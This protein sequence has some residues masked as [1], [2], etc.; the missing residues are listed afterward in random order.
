MLAWTAPRATSI[1][2]AA[3]AGAGP[4][5]GMQQDTRRYLMDNPF[6]LDTHCF[7]LTE[8]ARACC[9]SVPY[10]APKAC[11]RGVRSS[12]RPP[13]PDNHN[14]GHADHTPRYTVDRS[15]S[16]PARMVA[17]A[18]VR[19]F[20]KSCEGRCREHRDPNIGRDRGVRGRL[21]PADNRHG[22][23]DHAK[24]TWSTPRRS[25]RPINTSGGTNL[26]TTRRGEQPRFHRPV[27]CPARAAATRS[28]SRSFCI[29]GHY[30]MD[31]H[32]VVPQCELW[33]AG[34]ASPCHYDPFPPDRDGRRGVQKG[35][36]GSPC[37]DPP[38]G[39][40]PSS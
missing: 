30:T 10:R 36:Q 13:S 38:A 25:R 6:L 20:A 16:A 32:D 28:T 24:G 22:H 12:I 37:G 5:I 40:D 15:R 4:G 18:I 1:Y 19:A 33:A 21:G 7:E 9:R 31:R 35:R 17:T 29:G 23:L 39:L 34:T 11:G 26:P 3:A 14:T 8:G 27:A 2:Y